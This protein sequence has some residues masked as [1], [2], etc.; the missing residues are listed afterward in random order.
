AY[1]LLY[2]VFYSVPTFGGP[3]LSPLQAGGLALGLN[4]GAYGSEIVRG[5]LLGVPSGQSEAAVSLNLSAWQRLRY[6]V[7]PQALIAMLPPFGNL[8]IEVLKGTSL[9]G[10]ITLSDLF[11]EARILRTNR[12]ASSMTIFGTVLVIYFV[13]SQIL[14]FGVRLA[15]RYAARGLDLS[16]GGR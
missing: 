11:F 14:A 2:W 12:V 1:I 4:M 7:L 16:R 10:Y 6:V 8:L 5:A 9:V 15:E 3:S 13:M